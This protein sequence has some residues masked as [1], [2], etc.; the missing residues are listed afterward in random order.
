MLNLPDP[1][2]CSATS[3][4]EALKYRQSVREYTPG[5]LTLA[6]L[7]QLLWSAYGVT[8]PDGKR[9]APS[10]KEVFPLR[11]YAVVNDVEGLD[12]GLYRYESETH[13]LDELQ[14]GEFRT[15]LFAATYSQ[16]AVANGAA[17]LVF[18]AVFAIA[19]AEFGAS[20]RQYVYMDL[21]HAG[22]NVYLQAVSL[23]VGTVVIGAFRSGK[24]QQLLALPEGET[25]LYLMPIGRL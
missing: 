21:G 9:T 23:K 15:D 13:R 10:A 6:E 18:A 22:Q 16:T 24:V 20:G 7:G 2:L 3:I 17:I 4:E 1:K 8:R 11:I 14:R 25:P 5:K 12:Q 19:E